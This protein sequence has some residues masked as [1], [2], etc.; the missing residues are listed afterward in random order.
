MS[1]VDA[2]NRADH[3]WPVPPVVREAL[4]SKK[5]VSEYEQARVYEY[6]YTLYSVIDT[7]LKERETSAK[8]YVHTIDDL[9]AMIQRQELRIKA[10]EEFIS[11]PQK[12]YL[13]A[14]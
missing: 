8:S 4:C 7:L 1:T 3:R 10:V 13:K 9:S 11:R 2:T 14:D 12:F 5:P 6:I